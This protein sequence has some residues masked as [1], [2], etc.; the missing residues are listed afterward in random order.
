MK[1][2]L[3]IFIVFLLVT[4]FA[5]ASIIDHATVK[6]KLEEKMQAYYKELLGTLKLKTNTL[7][8]AMINLDLRTSVDVDKAIKNIK[9]FKEGK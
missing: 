9:I 3:W 5:K 8:N 6:K 1:G 7:R 4:G 2:G